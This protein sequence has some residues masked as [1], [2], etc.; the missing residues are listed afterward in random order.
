MN[1]PI[2]EIQNMIFG[3]LR[4]YYSETTTDQIPT[5]AECR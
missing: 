3:N 5:P 1:E 4:E 2:D